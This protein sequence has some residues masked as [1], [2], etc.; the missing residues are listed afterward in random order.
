MRLQAVAIALSVGVFGCS[1][2][3]LGT[4]TAPSSLRSS[5]APLFR[6]VDDLPASGGDNQTPGVVI[7]GEVALEASGGLLTT[8]YSFTGGLVGA[9]RPRVAANPPNPM[10]FF[11]Q[12]D[13]QGSH[14]GLL[15]GTGRFVD[16]GAYLFSFDVRP[17]SASITVAFPTTA[18]AFVT[19]ETATPSFTTVND[20]T[21]ASGQRLITTVRFQ[22]E[23]FGNT[24][25]TDTHCIPVS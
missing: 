18:G 17:N 4:P 12:P 19:T 7:R 23:Y 1:S 11:L 14:G 2:G 15:S 16:L 10:D 6:T 21:C 22:L 24:L 3:Q 25:V 13:G 8:T 9:Q 20:S 5:P